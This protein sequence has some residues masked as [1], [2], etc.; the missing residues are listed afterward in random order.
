[1]AEQN[2]HYVAY[3]IAYITFFL[4]LFTTGLRFYSR[5]V[6][7]NRWGWDDYSSVVVLAANIAQQAVLQMLLN[8]GC[9]IPNVLECS[10]QDVPLYKVAF[11]EEVVIYLLHFTI[12]TTFLLFYLRLSGNTR[13][14]KFVLA[15][16]VFN[17]SIFITSML[18]TFLQC[19]PFKEAIVPGSYPNAV[20]LD[21][22]TVMIIPPVLNI[23]M[24]LYILLLPI[25]TVWSLQMPLRGKL[26]VVSVMTFGVCSVTVACIRIPMI[27]SLTK[28]PDTSVQLGKM[29][30][31]AAAE[32]QAAIVA[33]NL[34]CIK[35]FWSRF[36]TRNLEGSDG[37]TPGGRN[38]Y[39]RMP[40]LGKK[41]GDM[42][43]NSNGEEVPL[44]TITRLERGLPSTESKERLFERAQNDG[45]P[46]YPV[47]D[48]QGS[49]KAKNSSRAEITV[50][51]KDEA[52]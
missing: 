1:M 33:V 46:I 18:L 34:P 5:A 49:T 47:K 44:G 17:A 25:A 40:F 2:L 10:F 50:T 36:K 8:L 22:L 19:I 45:G 30:I 24:D 27:I 13:F 32:V 51:T 3:A 7:M 12:K 26:E 6:L 21:Q 29:V 48:V 39:Y 42:N 23:T 4:G 41:A 14:Q 9:G 16:I 31:I 15:G 28:S 35:S 11:V 38:A 52:I 20:C 37:D 43:K